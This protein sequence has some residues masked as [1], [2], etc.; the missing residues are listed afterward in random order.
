MDE[1]DANCI[2]FIRV[3]TRYILKPVIELPTSI[4]KDAQFICNS[5]TYPLHHE[6]G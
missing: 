6:V 2:S 3:E 4:R 5:V 1:I